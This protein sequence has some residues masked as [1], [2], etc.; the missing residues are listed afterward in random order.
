MFFR[1]VI[2]C[3]YESW[4]DLDVKYNSV[5]EGLLKIHLQICPSKP[6]LI[7]N[8]AQMQSSSVLGK[9]ENIAIVPKVPLIC[10]FIY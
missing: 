8:F 4:S 1:F 6:L 5:V 9:V 3:S 2:R 10:T 7:L